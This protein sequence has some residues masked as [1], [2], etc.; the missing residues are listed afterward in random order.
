MN[1]DAIGA[2]GEIAGAMAV[3]VT[4]VYLASQVRQ[5]SVIMQADMYQK[6]ERHKSSVK[7]R[8]CI[9][10]R[11][12]RIPIQSSYSDGKARR[13]RYVPIRSFYD[14]LLRE[15]KYHLSPTRYRGD[16]S[17]RNGQPN[18]AYDARSTPIQL[19]SCCLEVVPRRLRT[20]ISRIHGQCDS[21][22]RKR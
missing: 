3:I 15:V 22:D 10:P 12:Y 1:W 5:N 13:P 7:Q 2:V 8:A 16:R 21:F 17:S 6:A 14:G 11:I 4:L 18:K 9:Q 19:G 20:K